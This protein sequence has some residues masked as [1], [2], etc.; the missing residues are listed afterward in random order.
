MIHY[1]ECRR[2]RHPDGPA[3]VTRGVPGVEF[4]SE[5]NSE[6]VVGEWRIKALTAPKAGSGSPGRTLTPL[7]VSVISHL[8][9]T[10]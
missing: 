9:T 10:D 1:D 7:S 2:L 6:A 3:A 4:P 5:F 8:Q